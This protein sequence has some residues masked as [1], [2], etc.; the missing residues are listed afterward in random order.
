MPKTT[1]KM[2]KK[3][4]VVWDKKKLPVVNI[5]EVNVSF[6]NNATVNYRANQQTCVHKIQS[7]IIEAGT[8]Y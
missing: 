3:E 8:P 1:K 2:P 5:K 4:T 6:V 7:Q